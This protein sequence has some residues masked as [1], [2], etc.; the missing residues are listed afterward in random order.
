MTTK[1]RLSSRAE[2]SRLLAGAAAVALLLLPACSYVPDWANPVSW[3]DGLFGDNV[4][5]PKEATG[6]K[7]QTESTPPRDQRFPTL[8]TVPERPRAQSSP[9]ERRAVAQGLVADRAGARYTDESL[10]AGP[11]QGQTPPQR[12]SRSDPASAEAVPPPA[13]AGQTQRP[14]P[15]PLT[16]GP[17][18]APLTGGAARAPAQALPVPPP[19]A[20]APLGAAPGGAMAQ[21]TPVPGAL[22]SGA[23][24]RGLPVVAV[25]VYTNVSYV[26]PG[27]SLPPDQATLQQVF[28]QH[29]AAQRLT[30]LNGQ[31][32]QRLA[33]PAAFVPVPLPSG[34][35]AYAGA[36]EGNGRGNASAVLPFALGAAALDAAALANVQ[37]LARAV[38]EGGA[39]LRVIGHASPSG[40]GDLELSVRRAEAVARALRQAGV[41]AERLI[42][43]GR[44]ASQPIVAASTAEADALSRR[45]EVFL[46]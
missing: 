30:R 29:L 8:A 34:V 10:R 44:G 21:V 43:E 19:A 41:P 1:M 31:A 39:V 2:P 23:P 27:L 6:R 20:F 37:E 25:P 35:A 36:L 14:V 16:A 5:P 12:P 7:P 3:Y 24:W 42:V 28:Q 9:E 33:A 4:P 45:V 38:R 32:E 13:P 22:S 11:G 26:V 40:A 18:P 17:V 15:G 46:Q